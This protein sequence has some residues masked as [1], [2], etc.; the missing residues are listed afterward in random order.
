M[1]DIRGPGLPLVMAA[2][3]ALLVGGVVAVT[4]WRQP[5]PEPLPAPAGPPPEQAAPAESGIRSNSPRLLMPPRVER[6][7]RIDQLRHELARA[8]AQVAQLEEFRTRYRERF[9]EEAE[10][11]WSAALDAASRQARALLTGDPEGPADAADV[12]P[13]NSDATAAAAGGAGADAP[14]GA[15][16]LTSHVQDLERRLEIALYLDEQQTLEIE[17]LRRD[18]T[19]ANEKLA[20]QSQAEQELTAFLETERQLLT[21]ASRTLIGLGAAAV[22][23]LVEALGSQDAGTRAWAADVLGAMGAAARP[24]LADLFDATSDPD[25]TARAAIRQAINTIER[26][27]DP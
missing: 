11:D 19:A 4:W 13:A 21:E 15:T 12:D 24:A 6:D 27:E 26:A 2:C 20:E 23:A 8:R 3:I 9:P 25:P 17:H 22:P 14:A 16:D 1:N 10:L 18:L 5:S 7:D